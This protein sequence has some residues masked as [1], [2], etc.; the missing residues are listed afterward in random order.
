ME[1]HVSEDVRRIPLERLNAF[2]RNVFRAL[3]L[4]EEESQLC[5][6]GLLQSELRGLPA[7]NQGVNRLPVY[8][9]RIREGLIAPGAPFEI[10]R[11]SPSLALVD[12]HN[13]LGYVAATR[14]MRLA[15]AKATATGIGAVFVRHSTHFGA[16][17]VHARRALDERCIG[18]AMSNAGP[19]MAPWGGTTPVL[20]TNPWALAVPTGAE[21]PLVLDM[22]LT[23]SGKGMM[24]WLAREM[25]AMPLDWAITR[26]GLTTEDPNA[27]L[28]GTLLPIGGA[29]GYGLSMMTD[30][31]TG[32]LT[33]AA[34]GT[35]PY[36]NPAFQDV[37]HLLMSVSIEWFM[38]WA[39]FTTRLET[40][41]QEIR[42]SELRPGVERIYL[43]GEI[44]YLRE[45]DK[46]AQGVPLESG[47]LD[48]LRQLADDLHIRF[49]LTAAS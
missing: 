43:P 39:D 8:V 40:L 5:A 33:G 38:P 31:L 10:V 2:T 19:E 46:T 21:M 15:V 49:E 28:D 27:A 44:E 22:A 6:D 34:F 20:G 26:A 36:R 24:M 29:K 30:I 3:G 47:V 25:R 13:A 41:I 18:I 16:A 48:T 32:V 14:A 1:H 37:G 23:T 9:E 17:G 45:R 12:A 35:A 11:E 7:Q 4:D 42:A